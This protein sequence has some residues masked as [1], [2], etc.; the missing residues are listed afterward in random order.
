MGK[1]PRMRFAFCLLAACGGSSAKPDAGDAGPDAYEMCHPKGVTGELQRRAGN[2]RLLAGTTFSDGKL[3][4]SI[5]D[6]DVRWDDVSQRFELYYMAAH[7]TSITDPALVQVI[8]HATSTDYTTWTV[9]DT[10]ALTANPDVA[11]WDHVNTETP[12]VVFDPLAPQDRR[13][14]MLYSGAAQKLAGYTFPEYAIGA[15]ISSDGKT[16]T[17]VG[18]VLTGADVYPGATG[19]IVADPELVLV[20]GTYHLFFSSFAANGTPTDYGVGHATSTDGLHWSVAEAP[21]KSLLRSQIDP[22]TGGGQPSVIYDA[23]HCTWELW[24][25]SDSQAEKDAQPIAFNN[26]AGVWHADSS[27]G[28]TWHL[29]YTSPRDLAWDA[30]A[31]GEH[32][33]WLTGADVASKNGGL[34]MLYVGFDDQNI[35]NGFVLPDHSAQGFRPGVMALDAATRDLP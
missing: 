16:F 33:G 25:S 22:T 18:R 11:A 14:L 1:P 2:P 19:A 32:L 8:R 15:A 30:S 29:A 23:F 10:P 6:P 24:Q 20:N 35:P 9:D 31:P 17:R 7:G 5:S 34:L 12:T 4:V 3:D 21:I 27:D 28:Q 26:T 13:Y